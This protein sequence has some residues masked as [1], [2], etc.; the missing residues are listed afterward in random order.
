MLLQ[1]SF[2]C[3]HKEHYLVTVCYVDTKRM[4]WSV[5]LM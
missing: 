4:M 5:F 2:L 1:K 3:R